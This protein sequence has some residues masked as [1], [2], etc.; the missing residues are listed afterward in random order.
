MTRSLGGLVLLLLVAARLTAAQT[1]C[2]PAY[3][4]PGSLWTQSIGGAPT[5]SQMIM[6]P[7]SGPGTAVDLNYRSAVSAAQAK[8]IKIL[9]YVH[10]SYGQRSASV[11]QAEMDAYYL[12]YG[13]DGIF[14]D[15]VSSGL[16]DLSYYT[17]LSNAIRSRTKC[18]V[19]LNPGVYPAEAYMA[20]ADSILVFEGTYSTYSKATTPAW[21]FNYPASRFYHVVYAT[22]SSTRMKNVVL[23]SRQRNAGCLYVTPDSGGNPYDTLPAYWSAELAELRK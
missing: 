10:T 22:S 6:N 8:G 4:Y 16:A 19:M 2:I 13:V 3:Y 12:W 11:V 18:F 7:N 20:L 9:G 14:L 1:M 17:A 23:W 5:V 21:A 15:E